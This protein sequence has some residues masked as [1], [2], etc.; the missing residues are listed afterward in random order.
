MSAAAELARAPIAQ[1]VAIVARALAHRYGRARGLE[2]TD[3]ELSGPGVVAVTGV[4]GAGK[5]T[6]L[7][8]LAGLL[9]PSDGDSEV[10]VDGQA[11]SAAGRRRHIGYAAPD[12]AF[13][14]EMSACENLCFA[15]EA[16]GMAEPQAAAHAALERVGLAS[17]AD[18]RAG[19]LSSGMTQRLRIASALLHRPSV[20]LLDEPGSHLDDAGR[21]RL[22]TVIAEAARTGLVLVATNDEREWRL[23][24]ERIQ[25][26]GRGLGGPP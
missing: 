12:L 3:F 11:L 22:E 19:A 20:L 21:E 1:T 17:R 16:R 10:R 15:A 9:R 23:A 18:D 26:R 8:V 24:R 13:Y 7:R 14:P 4:N 6:L 2:R 25:L 5:S